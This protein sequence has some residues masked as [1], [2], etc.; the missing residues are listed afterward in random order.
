MHM[1]SKKE[2]SSEEMG[3]TKRYRNPTV[4]L[5]A[6]GEVHTYEEAQVFGHDLNQ[7]RTVQPLVE[8]PAVLSLV[9]CEDH[10]FSNEWVSCQKDTFDPKW[11]NFLQDGQFHT[12]CRSRVFVNSGRGSSFLHRHQRILQIQH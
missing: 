1:M 2:L 5:T 11:E 7:L 4:N 3:T 10:G 12:S 6:D 8:T 9:I